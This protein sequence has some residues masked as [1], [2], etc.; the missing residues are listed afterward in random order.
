MRKEQEPDM[1]LPKEEYITDIEKSSQK[2]LEASEQMKKEA[3]AF[4]PKMLEEGGLKEA[5]KKS[6]SLKRAIGNISRALAHTYTVSDELSARSK[7]LHTQQ[8]KYKIIAPPPA[9][10][11]VDAEE[12]SSRHFSEGLSIY[13]LLLVCFIG[14]FLGVVVELLWCLFTH[15]YLESRSG[16][17]YGPFNPLYGA[18][19]VVLTLCLYDLRNRSSWLSFLNGMVVGSVVEYACSWAQE[20][21]FGSR[22]W[23]YSH[24]PFNLNGRICLLYSIFWGILGVLWIKKVYPR[25]AELI[26]KI[27]N[28]SGKILTWA[29]TLFFV[30]NCVMS[31]A[32]V[33][34]WSE[35]ASN[36]EPSNSFEVF[37]DERFPDERLEKIYANMEF[38]PK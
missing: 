2:L 8:K 12:H 16:V 29:L 33:F 28:H 18:G 22:S 15:G 38:M 20:T 30:F 14:S 31:L 9:N 11:F 3:E 36:L 4:Y 35:R 7:D 1:E 21:A 17:V 37:L 5:E 25:M 32:A 27:P 26:L 10:A 34:R 13:K 24:M 23:D 6:E 19:A